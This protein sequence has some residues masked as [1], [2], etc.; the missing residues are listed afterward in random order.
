[1]HGAKEIVE[2]AS[3]LPV[4]ERIFVVDQ[5]LRTLNVPNADIDQAWI[6]EANRRLEELRD[7]RASTIPADEVFERARKRFA[8]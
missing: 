3:A 8:R 6:R 2:E 7:G 4:E 1:M 5:L